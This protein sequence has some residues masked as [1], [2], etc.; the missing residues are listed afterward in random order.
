MIGAENLIHATIFFDARVWHVLICEFLVPFSRRMKNEGIIIDLISSL[1]R[2]RGDHINVTLIPMPGQ[3]NMLAGYFQNGIRDFIAANPSPVPTRSQPP[4]HFFMDFPNNSV[5]FDVFPVIMIEPS[6]LSPEE[7]RATLICINEV[8]LNVIATEE[9]T[10][11][12]LFT[13][14]TYMTLT[15]VKML[16]KKGN[17]PAVC[18]QLIAVYA[19]FQT[20]A[21]VTQLEL[22]D[23]E[24]TDNLDFINDMVSEIWISPA[25]AHSWLLPWKLIF[26]RMTTSHPKQSRETHF[27]Y[28]TQILCKQL[29]LPHQVVLELLQGL[30]YS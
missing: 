28:L 20:P 18:Q 6:I 4:F 27:Y 30:S 17:I 1:G 11:E 14:V 16:E 22:I 23:W 8:L 24:S 2:Q 9:I 3:L 19:G 25:S 5:H 26:V 10:F 29:D 21:A 15:L 7:E 13:T 12:N